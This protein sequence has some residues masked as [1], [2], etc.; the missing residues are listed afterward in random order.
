MS[1]HI[2]T[3][4]HTTKVKTVCLPGLADIMTKFVYSVTVIAMAMRHDIYN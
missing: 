1:A 2:Q 4:K 3:D